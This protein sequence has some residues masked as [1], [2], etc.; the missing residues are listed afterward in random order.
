MHKLRERKDVLQLPGRESKIIR[1]A[2]GATSHLFPRAE[3]VQSRQ[4]TSSYLNSFMVLLNT[5]GKE[6][7]TKP[8]MHWE[9]NGKVFSFFFERELKSPSWL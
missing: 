5:L 1:K 7:G 2:L 9:I 6:P 4:G 8:R 3:N